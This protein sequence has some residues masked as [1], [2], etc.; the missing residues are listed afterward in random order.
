MRN[1]R[2][3]SRGRENTMVYS[4]INPRK[5]VID[6]LLQRRSRL[7]GATLPNIEGLRKKRTMPFSV[8]RCHTVRV[9]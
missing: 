8:G 7:Y 4:D 3:D 6:L 1:P 9:R 2:Y 5:H